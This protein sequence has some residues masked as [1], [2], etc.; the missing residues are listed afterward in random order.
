M[1]LTS[2]RPCHHALSIGGRTMSHPSNREDSPPSILCILPTPYA[3]SGMPCPV[4]HALY[5]TML[6]RPMPL[7]EYTHDRITHHLPSPLAGHAQIPTLMISPTPQMPPPPPN[8]H[9]STNPQPQ[10]RAAT[11]PLSTSRRAASPPSVMPTKTQPNDD[12]PRPRPRPR[13]QPIDKDGSSHS[14][15]YPCQCSCMV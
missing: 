3:M 10:K 7:P 8:H 6:R 14:I 2:E 1:C 13:A 12:G 5:I 9:K 15:S 11:F 4:C